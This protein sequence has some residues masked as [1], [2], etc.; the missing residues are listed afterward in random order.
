[1]GE[2]SVIFVGRE[3]RPRLVAVEETGSE[4]PLPHTHTLLFTFL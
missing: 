4:S 2:Y 3:G 1:M